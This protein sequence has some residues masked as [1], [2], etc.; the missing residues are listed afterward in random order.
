[1]KSLSLRDP[2][3]ANEN[4]DLKDFERQFSANEDS[5]FED[6]GHQEGLYG[7]GDDDQENYNS[8]SNFE[9]TKTRVRVPSL[10]SVE[11]LAGQLQTNQVSTHTQSSSFDSAQQYENLPDPTTRKQML[12]YPDAEEWILSEEKELYSITVKHKGFTYVKRTKDMNVLPCRFLYKYKRNPYGVVLSRKTRLVAGG[13][14]QQYAVDYNELDLRSHH[15]NGVSTFC[16]GHCSR[17]Q[18]HGCKV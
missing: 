7:N 16:V 11:A 14:K 2:L 6:I 3:S 12:S 18:C 9:E 17:Q 8:S 1:M 15:T 5:T 13:H 4:P 10:R